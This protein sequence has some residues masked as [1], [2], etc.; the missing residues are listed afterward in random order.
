MRVVQNELKGPAQPIVPPTA[1]SQSECEKLS[2]RT[3]TPSNNNP[4]FRPVPK[5]RRERGINAWVAC[6]VA[7]L[8]L[9]DFWF[10]HL[11][12]C[13]S[14]FLYLCK[15]RNQKISFPTCMPAAELQKAKSK[16]VPKRSK[17]DPLKH[18]YDFHNLFFALFL[19]SRLA[20][21]L[22]STG[23]RPQLLWFHDEGYWFH[24][25]K[26]IGSTNS[27]IDPNYY[28]DPN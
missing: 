4:K 17:T 15:K 27:D 16:K 1:R 7:C 5:I 3:L 18:R 28:L 13:C 24:Y 12:I 10:M 14:C 19:K 20:V 23:G 9:S 26:G 8:R 2:C 21:T 11:Y 25:F 6:R 22:P